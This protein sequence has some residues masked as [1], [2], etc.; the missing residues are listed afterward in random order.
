MREGPVSVGFP[1]GRCNRKPGSSRLGGDDLPGEGNHLANRTDAW[2]GSSRQEVV[3]IRCLAV[4]TLALAAGCATTPKEDLV[5]RDALIAE[6][7]ATLDD[8]HA[9]AA[10]ADAARYF[11]HFAADG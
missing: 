10:A 3:V 7:R 9:A 11:G 8:F 5:D 4:L 1:C 2:A 6:A